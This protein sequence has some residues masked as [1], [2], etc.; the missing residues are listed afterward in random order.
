MPFLF[1]LKSISLSNY[2][3]ICA[4]N[5]LLHYIASQQLR[6]EMNIAKEVGIRDHS[7]R[8]TL[9][10]TNFFYSRIAKKSGPRL[11]AFQIFIIKTLNFRTAKKFFVTWFQLNFLYITASNSILIECRHY[12]LKHLKTNCRYFNINTKFQSQ[13]D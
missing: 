10:S 1:L 4:F 13:F 2:F 8:P 12:C 7:D 9:N 11:I 3:T 6:W 5:S